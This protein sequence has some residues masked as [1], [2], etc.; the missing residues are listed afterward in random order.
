MNSLCSSTDKRI[1]PAIKF[2]MRVFNNFFRLRSG[3][4]H[5]VKIV[6]DCNWILP[7]NNMNANYISRALSYHGQPLQK[8]WDDERGVEDLRRLNLT[9]PNYSIY[10]ERQK[11]FTFQ[12]RAKRLKIHQFLARKAADLYDRQLVGNV[13]E[14]SWLA[15]MSNCYAPQPPIEFYL[16]PKDKRK[17]WAYRMSALKQGDIVFASVQKV[18]P[19]ANRIIVKP[20]CT[21]EPMHF[22]L[23]DIPIKVR[24]QWAVTVRI[25][26]K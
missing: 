2:I 10:Q 15:Q 7:V 6:M 25:S 14:D 24:K 23:A 4:L 9:Q 1:Y 20:L 17:A 16:N 22:Y 3:H 18:V 12:E 13:M 19:N 21:A 26:F 8:I 11:Y 5:I